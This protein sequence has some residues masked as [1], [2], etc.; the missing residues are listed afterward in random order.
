MAMVRAPGCHFLVRYADGIVE[1][2]PTKELSCPESLSYAIISICPGRSDG[3]QKNLTRSSL[4]NR[5][6]QDGEVLNNFGN[7]PTVFA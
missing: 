2:R 7:P 4:S 6:C 5:L 1:G 3:E